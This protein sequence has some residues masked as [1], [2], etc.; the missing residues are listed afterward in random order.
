[1]KN[2]AKKMK[3]YDIVDGRILHL[4]WLKHVETL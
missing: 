4:G 2:N 3:K 1:M